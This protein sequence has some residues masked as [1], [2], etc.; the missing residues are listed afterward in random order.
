M[1][2]EVLFASVPVAKL[3]VA[4]DWYLNSFSDASRISFPTATR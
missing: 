3:Q 4:M 2:M 1:T